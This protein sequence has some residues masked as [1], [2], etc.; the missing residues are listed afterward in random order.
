MEDAS[1]MVKGAK[2]YEYAA[3]IIPQE[4]RHDLGRHTYL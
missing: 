3:Q 4:S 1:W 2:K